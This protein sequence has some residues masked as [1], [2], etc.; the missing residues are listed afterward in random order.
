MHMKWASCLFGEQ[1]AK[2]ACMMLVTNIGFLAN[3]AVDIGDRRAFSA[4]DD[5][6]KFRNVDLFDAVVPAI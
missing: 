6:V 1:L 2:D 5:E 4:R 3:I